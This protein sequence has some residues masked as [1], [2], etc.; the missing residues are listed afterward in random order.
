MDCQ[1]VG[2]LIANLRKEKSMT[3]KNLADLLHISDKTVSKWERG[4]GCPD[5]SL[6]PQL[7]AALN[8]DMEKIL[9][10]D[11]EA[12]QPVGGNMK[13]LKF[14]FCPTCGNLISSTASFAASCCGR[15]LHELAAQKSDQHHLLRIEPVEDQ[16]F[17]TSDHAMTKEHYISFV[18]LVTGDKLLLIKQYPE[19]GLQLRLPKKGHGKLFYH[20]IR[21]GLFYQL[22]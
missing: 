12:G 20:C 6:L 8:V 3:Q 19:W 16:W 21:H 15:K 5:I 4:L 13:K 14:Y 9:Q 18:A 7:S 22:L 1:K 11:L 10:G 2:A 17:V